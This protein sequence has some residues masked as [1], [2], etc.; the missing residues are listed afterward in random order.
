MTARDSTPTTTTASNAERVVPG[1]AGGGAAGT[2]GEPDLPDHEE[3]TL[4]RQHA[5]TVE[6]H[7]VS[8]PGPDVPP[9][10]VG[11]PDPNSPAGAP[12]VPDEPSVPPPDVGGTR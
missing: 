9:P 1:R 2:S 8:G 12:P 6:T 3:M 10:D 7:N 5:D 11:V 4:A